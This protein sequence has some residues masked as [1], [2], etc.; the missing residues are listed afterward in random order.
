[1]RPSYLLFAILVIAMFS[2][3]K[4]EHRSNSS[5]LCSF[6][7]TV[8]ACDTPFSYYYVQNDI[9]VKSR[10]TQ[11]NIYPGKRGQDSILTIS[12]T[13]PI[14]NAHS[15]IFSIELYNYNGIGTYKMERG[16][17]K[18]FETVP[19]WGAPI[20]T[21]DSACIT[22]A[23]EVVIDKIEQGLIYAHFKLALKYYTTDSTTIYYKGGYFTVKE[24]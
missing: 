24:P 17:N 7:D 6:D 12:A 3:S 16:K 4:K 23:G 15:P 18:A 14:P 5:Y 13:S 22:N 19:F 1:M 9:V 2:C 20:L 8:C 10:M 21:T 11:V